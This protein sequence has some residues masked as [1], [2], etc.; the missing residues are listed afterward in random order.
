MHSETVKKN[1]EN[2]ISVPKLKC[3]KYMVIILPNNCQL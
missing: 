2:H 3:L 1:H